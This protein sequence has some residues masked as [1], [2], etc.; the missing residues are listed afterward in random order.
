MERSSSAPQRVEDDD[1][2][3]AVDELGTEV[4]PQFSQNLFLDAVT[5]LLS[6]SI[7][8]KTHT[9][10]SQYQL[11]ADVGRHQDDRCW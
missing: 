3:D 9:A 7:L 8:T 4:T 2:V 10:A 6:S 11:A 5:N 1:L